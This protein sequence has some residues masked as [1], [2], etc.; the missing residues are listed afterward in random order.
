MNKLIVSWYSKAFFYSSIVINF[1]LSL[2]IISLSPAFES[3]SFVVFLDVFFSSYVFSVTI[4]SFSSKVG[5]LLKNSSISRDPNFELPTQCAGLL[6]SLKQIFWLK[7]RKMDFFFH[8]NSLD[9]P[10]Q[11]YSSAS[12]IYNRSNIDYPWLV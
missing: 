6:L 11:V 12:E 1:S 2:W 5:V 10:T 8:H 7:T 4:A 3:A 9:S